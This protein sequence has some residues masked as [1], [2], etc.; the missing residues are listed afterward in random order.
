[1]FVKHDVGDIVNNLVKACFDEAYRDHVKGL[2]NPYG[3]GNSA[4][5]IKS[6]IDT[7]DLEDDKWLVKRKLC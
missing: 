7:V 4:E 6:F 3:D 2:K 1:V 5:R